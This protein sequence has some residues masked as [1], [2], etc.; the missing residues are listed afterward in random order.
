LNVGAFVNSAAR[1]GAAV[2]VAVGESVSRITRLDS[3]NGAARGGF[4]NGGVDTVPLLLPNERRRN[5]RAAESSEER[6]GDDEGSL[7]CE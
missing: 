6:G 7:H 2:L 5:G 3:V 1:V 4:N